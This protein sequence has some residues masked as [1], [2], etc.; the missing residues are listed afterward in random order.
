MTK[1]EL[2]VHIGKCDYYFIKCP[3]ENC[4]E[5]IRR[6]ERQE[7]DKV[8]EIFFHRTVYF[9]LRN[10]FDAKSYLPVLILFFRNI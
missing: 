9:L 4:G 3:M 8:R 10:I 6:H 2:R 1:E 7:H 5:T